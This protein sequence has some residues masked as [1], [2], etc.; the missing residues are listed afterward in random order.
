MNKNKNTAKVGKF[1]LE[2]KTN[3]FSNKKL[4]VSG[5]TFFAKI[6]KGCFHLQDSALFRY[7]AVTTHIQITMTKV[8]ILSDSRRRKHP[9][10]MD[11]LQIIDSTTITL[12][13]N[14][15][16]KGV[17]RHPKSGRKKGGIKMHTVRI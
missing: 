7:L 8:H 6:K 11:K 5:K 10:W 3:F 15:I 17:G 2:E 9:Q 13:S 4:L 1:H 14:L 16:F 12:F